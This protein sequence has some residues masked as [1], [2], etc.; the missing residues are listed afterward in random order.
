VTTR[1]LVLRPVRARDRGAVRRLVQLY[2][3]DL[4]G[5][6]WA[7]D[8]EGRFGSPRWHRRFWTRRGRHHFVIRVD[9]RLAGFALVRDR[10]HFAGRGVREISDF[11]VLR[12]YRRQRVGT[13]AARWLF[14]RFSG[15]WEIAELSWNLP[16]QRF[17]R[18]VIGRC[19]VGRVVEHRRRQDDLTF[20]VQHFA[21]AQPRPASPR[22]R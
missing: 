17:W 13:D 15:R 12:K 3:Y 7:P 20:I 16:A 14:A 6:R 2:I 21:T 22:P 1:R 11:F 9:G 4:V 18:R 5:D 10:A 8:A 19:A